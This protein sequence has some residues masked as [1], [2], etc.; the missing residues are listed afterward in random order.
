MYGQGR[1]PKA[2]VMPPD[3]VH[4]MS[5]SV[6]LLSF[7]KPCPPLR[8]KAECKVSFSEMI[9]SSVTRKMASIES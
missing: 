2:H 8:P 3:L 4:F 1:I 7:P 6:A 5:L 9:L